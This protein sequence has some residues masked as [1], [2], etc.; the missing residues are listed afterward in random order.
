MNPGKNGRN[1]P[2]DTAK[3]QVLSYKVTRPALKTPAGLLE[4]LSHPLTRRAGASE[5]AS[6]PRDPGT[7]VVVADLT[8]SLI[9][10]LSPWT[11]GVVRGPPPRS[12]LAR[13]PERIFLLGP[14]DAA[15]Q[16]APC[17]QADH[18]LDWLGAGNDHGSGQHRRLGVPSGVQSRQS[19]PYVWNYGVLAPGS[20]T[21]TVTNSSRSGLEDIHH[22]PSTADRGHRSFSDD[23]GRLRDDRAWQSWDMSSA[24]DIQL[25]GSD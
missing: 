1:F 24:A 22:Q 12:Q 10:G 15:P 21:L 18:L 20:Y 8:Q 4:P 17:G 6:A 19:S 25:T 5:D 13:C 16:L 23:R 2:I 7:Q 3:Y 9:P 14:S 11:D